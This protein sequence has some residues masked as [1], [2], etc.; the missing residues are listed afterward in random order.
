M[1][2]KRKRKKLF[3]KRI[4]FL[5]FITLLLLTF[6]GVLL[7]SGYLD[8]PSA[9]EYLD[10]AGE[11]ASEQTGEQKQPQ[12]RKQS[13]ALAAVEKDISGY[14]S[15][16]EGRYGVYFL[17]LNNAEELGINHEASFTAASTIKIPI[18]LYLYK[19][20]DSGLTDP[21]AVLVY[22]K[23]DY[24]E[25]T[26]KLRYSEPGG[27]YTI[28]ELSRLSIV[29]SDNVAANMLIRYLGLADIKGYM[30]Q[31]GG[32]VV[33]DDKNT[34]CPRDMGLYMKLV[35]DLYRNKKESG[36]QLV[37]YFMNTEFN[38]RIPAGLPSSVK[39]AH[40]IGTQVR[41]FND[42]GIVFAAKPYILSIM[43]DGIDEGKAAGV[44]ANISRKIY[45][46]MTGK[47]R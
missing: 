17:D 7:I 34:S 36:K 35:Y 37:D 32:I 40:K 14:L 33:D 29:N 47:S 10:M 30:R 22:Q 31:V 18:N 1:N 24:E 43:S 44:I 8:T 5:F 4:R 46:Y 11:K 39:V 15:E 45:S 16:Q 19:K 23:D 28:R 41:A 26:G 25:G 21:G 6:W 2:V 42:V 9:F 38:D 13:R 27:K 20:I 3:Y 12:K